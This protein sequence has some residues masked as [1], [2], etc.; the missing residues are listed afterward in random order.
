MFKAQEMS[1]FKAGDKVICINNAA[2]E[3]ALIIGKIYTV[4]AI[5]GI[6][7]L[8]KGISGVLIA[9]RFESLKSEKKINKPWNKPG[10]EA[11]ATDSATD[12]K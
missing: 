11:T 6:Y 12:S 4:E 5:D 2:K 7:V 3:Y 9:S 8:I 1:M 10:Y